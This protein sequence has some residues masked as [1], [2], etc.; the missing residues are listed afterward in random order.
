[1]IE[2]DVLIIGS[3]PAGSATALA[4]SSYGV[5]NTVVTKYRWLSDTPRAHITNQ[6]TM[7]ILRD[8]GVDAEVNALAAPQEIMG[9]TVFCTSLVGEELGRIRTW[10]THPQRQADYTLA[11]PCKICDMPQHLMEPILL[12]AAAARGTVPRFNMEYLSLE[13]DA[14]G[15][16]ATILDR[17]AG[18]TYQIRAKYLVGADGGRSK[19]AQDIGLPMEGKMG[20]AGSMNIVF[21]ADLSKYVAHRPSVLYWVLQPGSN[22]GG[23]GM[24]LV[25]MVR[26]W[27]EWLIVWGYDIN[28]EPPV[29]DDAAATQIARNL[30]GD[31]D[32]AIKIKSSSVWTINHMHAK[33]YARG[34]VFCMGDAV[35]RH[36]PSN[37]LGSNTSIQDGYNLAW[38]L[39]YVLQGKAAPSLLDSYNA[40]RAPIGKQIVDRANQSISETGMI[41]DALGLG[42]GEL[43]TETMIANIAA[44]KDA[45]PAAEKQ[46]A[47]LR[48]AI[49]FKTYE[50]NCHGVEL[51]Q[52]YDSA[53]VVKDGTPEPAYT[54]DKE[55][56]F[57]ATTWP[58]ARLPHVWLGQ[59]GKQI[60]TLDLAG[61]GRFSL[62]T[63]ISGA[64]WAE[65]AKAAASA[66]GIP[67]ETFVIGPGRAVEDLFGDWA[68]ARETADGGCVLVRPDMHIAWRAHDAA[69][70]AADAEQQLVAV[71]G[72]IL[73]K[74]AEVA[75]QAA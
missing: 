52:R 58:G 40:E 66:Y 4:L 64:A 38:K 23:I 20:V 1:M 3:G 16:T 28:Q 6:R 69:A 19:V 36:P 67:L 13:Q 62:F 56:Y 43:T 53:A 60:S 72:Q 25:R 41:F 49:A 45:T 21:E 75:R 71:L 74:P 37:G 70:N 73:G 59:G 11:S 10:G 2:T 47:A 54:R 50:F 31:Q 42:H 68:G 33:E 65:G 44:R 63:G 39:A 15:V 9:N 35:H 8:F 57:Q 5:K 27:N 48:D 24:G 26:P 32:I 14:D 61:K 34:R 17:A 30:I 51:N 22:I 18:E 29:V 7:E 46:R 55:L 12:G